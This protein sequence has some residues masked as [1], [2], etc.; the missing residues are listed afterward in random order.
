MFIVI[1]GVLAILRPWTV[2]PIQTATPRAFEPVSYVSSIWDSRVLPTAGRS[3]I[4]LKSFVG[5][6]TSMS[7]ARA[8]FVKGTA[9]VDQIDRKS[10]VG[11][12]RLA[13]TWAPPGHVADLQIGPVI[14]GTAL[15]DALD[16]IRFT[17]FVNQLEFAGVASA[18]ND[19]V[20]SAVLQTAPD[21]VPGAE[22][23]FV[24]AAPVSGPLEIVPVKLTV[25]SRR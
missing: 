19:R 22:V 23:S 12:A 25:T 1:A 7:G 2:V 10:R 18:L 3:A 6:R 9:T 5:E 14:R 21:L 17:D 4:D 20:V 13:G 8:V 24:G 15:R 16:F 11:L